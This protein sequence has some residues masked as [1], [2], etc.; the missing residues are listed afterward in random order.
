MIRFTVL[1]VNDRTTSAMSLP[2]QIVIALRYFKSKKKQRRISITTLISVGGVL[3]GVMT[4]ITV[5]SVM[6]GFQD[7][8]KEK[9]L[10]VNAH[11]VVQ[12]FK[13]RLSDGESALE[14]IREIPGVLDSSPYVYGQ[15]M[16]R[17]GDRAHGVVVK[18]VDPERG[19]ATTPVLKGL[20]KGSLNDLAPA[21][22]APGIITGMELAANLGLSIGDEIDLI[23]PVGE[24]G[25]LGVLPKMK[26][27]RL[28]GLFDAG[29]YEY[30]SSLA[31]IHIGE[32]RSFF[33]LDDSV[34]GLEVR[35]FDIYKAQEVAEQIEKSLG[36]PYF[37]RD[38]MQMNRNLFSALKLEKVVMFI[39]LTL[40][41]IVASFNIVSNLIMIVMEKSR[42][43]AILRAMGATTRGI[44]S[45]FII[46][47]LVIGITGTAGG[48]IGGY[49]LCRLLKEYRFIG[50]PADVYY[51]SYLPVRMD[52]FDFIVVP[53]AAI[54]ISFLA[55]L[56]PSW[57]AS[58]L[59]PVEPLRYE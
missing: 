4:L 29:M 17:S 6:G 34:T 10:G 20:K 35:V 26:K 55:T 22:E 59:D 18:G 3:L 30:D 9:I 39:I 31:F 25:P 32:A 27:F 56:Y 42:E 12:S 38:W 49:V 40:I 24:A 47:G 28:A 45:I 43:I 44:M 19:P 52:L 13:G 11:V 8:L 23:S 48:L 16:I 14:R 21:G 57:R 51:L 33:Q 7:D 15:V 50:L 58:G 37:A 36:T 2:Y 54:F 41:V 46:H 5:L 1:K 53:A